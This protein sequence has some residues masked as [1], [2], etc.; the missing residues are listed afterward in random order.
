VDIDVEVLDILSVND[1][2]FSITMTM[3][4]SVMWKEIRIWTNR[5]IEEVGLLNQDIFRYLDFRA[6]TIQS[7]STS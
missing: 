5:S 3:Y 2:E 6:L 4:F 7:A 1:R